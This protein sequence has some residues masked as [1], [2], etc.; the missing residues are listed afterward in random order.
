M[1]F[2]VVDTGELRA[3]SYVEDGWDIISEICFRG[4]RWNLCL[5]TLARPSNIVW[6][7]LYSL[8]MAS[9]R[10]SKRCR[11]EKPSLSTLKHDIFAFSD[12]CAKSKLKHISVVIRC[13]SEKDI[14]DLNGWTP[15]IHAILLRDAGNRGTTSHRAILDTLLDDVIDAC[16]QKGISLNAGDRST[17]TGGILERPL[18]LAAY[19]GHHKAVQKLLQLGASP[20]F[21]NGE[22]KTALHACLDNPLSLKRLRE[23]DRATFAVLVAASCLTGSFRDYKSSAPGTKIY[24][25]GDDA[26]FGTPLLRSIRF[27]N[28][29]SFRLLVDFGAFLTDRD[30]LHLKRKKLLRRLR[31][32]ITTYHDAVG[33]KVNNLDTWSE[34]MDWS[35]PP[36]WKNSVHLGGCCGLPEGVF[37]S[38]LVPLLPRH[39]FYNDAQLAGES[40]PP[41]ILASMGELELRYRDKCIIQPCAV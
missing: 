8:K 9:P 21:M 11:T 16:H 12:Y 31:K 35:F 17:A 25:A 24:I 5:I 3:R 13:A 28:D 22:G 41:R 26:T 7:Y 38:H 23:D 30:V 29:D 10:K 4:E 33:Q 18:V 20:D 27:Q 36:T 37:K 1:N 6:I 15:L 19:F 32:M 40:T 2:A 39:W 14:E 34:A